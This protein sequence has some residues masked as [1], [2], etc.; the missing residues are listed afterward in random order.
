MSTK[1]LRKRIAL[2]AVSALGA[3]LLSVVAVPS[4]S[5]AGTLTVAANAAAASTGTAASVGVLS[6][7]GSGTTQTAVMLS[8]G[9]LVA[10]VGSTAGNEVITVSGGY[11]SEADAG[12]LDAGQKLIGHSA[13]GDV[14]FKPS[15]VG[16]P[17]V[18]EVYT[19][20]TGVTSTTGGTLETRLTVTVVATNEVG[21]LSA[22][23]SSVLWGPG[24]TAGAHTAA[25]DA[26]STYRSVQNAEKVYGYIELLD[27]YGDY[28]NTASAFVAATV[29]GGAVVDLATST[30]TSTSSST[31]TDYVAVS[32]LTNGGLWF[33]IAQGT[34]N[35]PTAGTLTVKYNDTVLATKSFTIAG[36]VA[37]FT[38]SAAS[39]GSAYSSDAN[40]DAYTFTFEDAA[41]NPVYPANQTT[42][43]TASASTGLNVAVTAIAASTA[44]SSSSL[45]KGGFTCSGSSA[46]AGITDSTAT[47]KL[48]ILDATSNYVYSNPVSFSCGGNHAAFTAS[49]D[50][51]T[52]TPGSI[53]TLTI[54]FVDSKGKPANDYETFTGS[55]ANIVTYV[56]HPG[57]VVA[58]STSSDKSVGGKK[59]YQ[60]VVGSTEGD[61]NMVVDV[62]AVRSANVAAGGTQA[63]LT[64]PYSIKASSTGVSNADVLKAIVSLI[65]SINKQIAALQ[66]AL[67]KK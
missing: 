20:A 9:T 28:I 42:A 45:G 8:T 2:V 24:T 17:M 58:V 6:T 25:T 22:A 65:A 19:G 10:T 3:G 44:Y 62:P 21:V 39:I 33:E 41:G 50:K 29:T 18:I 5:A 53:A 38:V 61:Y 7:Y 64:V 27:A 52:Y 12:T 63:K 55:D 31:A 60:F 48:R 26:S 13:L 11:I 56:G 54:N 23:D 4:A 16:T 67:L 30:S 46:T 15:A 51:A 57:T 49:L 66:K 36:T 35:K 1:T 34:A 32:S 40:T 59:T 47:V 37:K 43:I 14:A